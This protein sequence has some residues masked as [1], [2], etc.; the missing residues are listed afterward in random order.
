MHVLERFGSNFTKF[1]PSNRSS[2]HD[3]HIEFLEFCLISEFVLK[4]T[5]SIS[6]YGRYAKKSISLFFSFSEF[7]ITI[8]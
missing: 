7:E 6:K 2:N 8:F 5:F 3:R 4:L 1:Y